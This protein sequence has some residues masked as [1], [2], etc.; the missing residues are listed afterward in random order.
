[1]L[2]VGWECDLALLTV[3]EDAF[4]KGV[5]TIPFSR[6]L[7]FLLLF[8]LSALSCPLLLSMRPSD[9]RRAAWQALVTCLAYD[10]PSGLLVVGGGG[11][12]LSA[13][14]RLLHPTPNPNLNLS[15]GPIPN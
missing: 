14:A 5:P 11:A 10:Q 15:P 2:A 1:M 9:W 3:A 8:S 6:R 7:P 13:Q 12:A 4:W